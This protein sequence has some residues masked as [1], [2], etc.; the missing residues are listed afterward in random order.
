M[1]AFQVIADTQI[2]LRRAG[3]PHEIAGAAPYLASDSSSYTTG[4]VI[5]VDGGRA[6]PA[7]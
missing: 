6:H 4:A 1:E 2:P 5:E 7:G 3:E